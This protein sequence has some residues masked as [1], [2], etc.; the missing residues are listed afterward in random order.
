VIQRRI[1]DRAPFDAES[2]HAALSLKM[3]DEQH[4]QDHPSDL[5]YILYG[6]YQVVRGDL[7]WTPP[8]GFV[9]NWDRGTF[10]LIVI[11]KRT[12]LKPPQ[13]QAKS[14]TGT[15]IAHGSLYQ[16]NLLADKWPWLAGAGDVKTGDNTVLSV[17][18]TAS[19]PPAAAQVTFI[20]AFPRLEPDDP[21]IR[22]IASAPVE[23]SDLL[24]ALV[25][26]GPD[27]QLYW[28]A[29]LYG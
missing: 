24:V 10:W 11:D 19:I 8:A 26:I 18:T 20:A 21:E 6:K 16:L 13:V 5:P 28:A 14:A 3:M 25:F 4:P 12:R 7:T 27:D 15:R 17:A 1:H 2:I 22:F 29:R 9:Q 23:L